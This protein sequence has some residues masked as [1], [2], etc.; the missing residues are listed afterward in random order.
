MCSFI[1]MSFDLDVACELKQCNTFT[2]LVQSVVHNIIELKKC[3]S[4][5]A[6]GVWSDF[7]ANESNASTGDRNEIEYLTFCS[8]LICRGM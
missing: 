2:M 7:R 4:L 3:K 5:I 8:F 1:I 6:W